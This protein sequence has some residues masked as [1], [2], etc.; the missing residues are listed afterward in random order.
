[1]KRKGFTLIELLVVIAIIGILATII[2]MALS[3]TRPKADKASAVESINASLKTAA[4]CV[5]DST[6]G[7]PLNTVTYGGDICSATNPITQAKWPGNPAGASPILR[8]TQFGYQWTITLNA[9]RTAVASVTAD[10]ADT[11]HQN[12]PISCNTVSGAVQS[13]Q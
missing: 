4:A 9:T 2:L 7:T 11:A 10:G 6:S 8:R 3:N 12:Y 13:C 5:A 1:M